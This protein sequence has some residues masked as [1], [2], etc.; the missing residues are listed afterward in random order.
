MLRASMAVALCLAASAAVLP[1]RAANIAPGALLEKAK[2]EQGPFLDTW[3]QLVSIDTGTG[4]A[5]GLKQVGDTLAARLEAL[6]ATVERV[7]VTKG[8]G[9]SI[10]GR[11]QGKGT[12]RILMTIHYDTVFPE[13]T[14]AQRPFRIDGGRAYGP[15]VVDAKGGVA[16]VLHALAVLTSLKYD[17]FGQLVV[18]FNPDEET[19]STG[20]QALISSL[21][22]DSDY[23]LSFEG[24]DDDSVITATNGINYLFLDVA[25]RASHAGAAPE[26]GRN[27]VL[28]LS[29]QLLR[30][31]G[32][33]DPAKSTTV[34][35][36][37]F[38]GGDKRNVIPAK[39]SAE[40]DMRY[41]DMSEIDR[42][43]AEIGRVTAVHRV[44]DT[45]VTFRLE[46]GRPPLPPNEATRAL[47]AVAQERYR[48]I[49]RTLGTV[50]A[51]FG[52]DAGYAANAGGKAAVIE[53]LGIVGQ[54]IHTPEETAEIDSVPARVYLAAGLVID[55]SEKAR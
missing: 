28:E 14:V 20:S 51:R 44:P 47:A 27:A 49:G 25:G 4:Y 36:T 32:L 34:N 15:G 53:G 2:A 23:V 30:L 55:L 46:R 48:Q 54:G 40:G 35:W 52:T 13:G 38:R 33:G 1:A 21:A 42:V 3:R 45:T 10:V 39:A 8:V 37:V 5:P 19:G 9:Q 50:D 7:P 24:W 11:F 22:R 6:G 29:H 17:G 41:S 12:A 31:D 43:T 18:Q 26:Q 16:I